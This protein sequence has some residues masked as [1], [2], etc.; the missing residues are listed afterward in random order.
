M[1]D[2][3]L[4]ILQQLRIQERARTVHLRGQLNSIKDEVAILQDGIARVHK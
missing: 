4:P 3:Q 1:V 2:D